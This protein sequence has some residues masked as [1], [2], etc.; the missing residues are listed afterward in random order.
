MMVEIIRAGCT[1]RLMRVLLIGGTGLISVGIIKHLLARGA[2]V[3]MFN[4]GKRT[5]TVAGNVKHVVGDRNDKSFEAFFSGRPFDVV[6]D[7]ICFTP[8]QAESS[9]RAFGERCE[10]FIFCS[11][12][13]TYGVKVPSNVLVDETLPQ[14]PN[15]E[16][17]RNKV[18]CEQI[19]R[20]ADE[21]GKFNTTIIRPSSTYGPGSP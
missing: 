11:T 21:S 18:A 8:Q 19:F 13:C 4:R 1:I 9:V 7:M 17:G 14:E 16:Y 20:R 10:H 15:S 2:D 6:I 12:V 5:S 3:T